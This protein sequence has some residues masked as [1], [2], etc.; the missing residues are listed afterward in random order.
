M[1]ADEDFKS[2]KARDSGA[3]QLLLVKHARQD[4]DDVCGAMAEQLASLFAFLK[5]DGAEESEMGSVILC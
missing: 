2:S 4:F 3:K 1:S 5:L